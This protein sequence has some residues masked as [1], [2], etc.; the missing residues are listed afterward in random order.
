MRSRFSRFPCS[1]STIAA[2]IFVSIFRCYKGMDNRTWQPE[3][4][5]FSCLFSIVTSISVLYKVFN[6]S[7]SLVT[8][9]IPKPPFASVLNPGPSSVMSIINNWFC[10]DNRIVI[11]PVPRGAI[12]CLTAFSTKG[13][14][15]H[16]RNLNRIR[17]DVLVYCQRVR[18]GETKLFEL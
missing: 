4:A 15:Q 2:V 8:A 9:R 16:S 13:L 5:S 1:S 14:Y 6:I 10:K 12:P 11:S 3:T 7:N 17:F 18:E